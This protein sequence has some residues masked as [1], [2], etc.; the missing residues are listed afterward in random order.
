MI[1]SMD[2]SKLVNKSAVRGL[3]KKKNLES[4]FN[5]QV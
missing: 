4:L 2:L 5:N 1:G 3:E